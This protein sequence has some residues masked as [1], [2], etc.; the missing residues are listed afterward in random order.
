MFLEVLIYLVVDS[1]SLGMHI[2]EL[3][4]GS[5]VI[6]SCYLTWEEYVCA[7]LETQACRWRSCTQAS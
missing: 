7:T 5:I 6:S 3:Y 4:D 2:V 1:S